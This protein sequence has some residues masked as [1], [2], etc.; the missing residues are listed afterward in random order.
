MNEETVDPNISSKPP[1]E[2]DDG[3]AAIGEFEGII[4]STN[5]RL[6]VVIVVGGFRAA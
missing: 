3:R 6:L 4:C 1:P 2:V 5:P